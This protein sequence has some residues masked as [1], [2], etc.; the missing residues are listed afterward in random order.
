[1]HIQM[2]CLHG[3]NWRHIWRAMPC[4]T[5]T[6][7]WLIDDLVSEPDNAILLKHWLTNEINTTVSNQGTLLFKLNQITP[8]P[9][10][11]ELWL[12]NI[13][14]NHS[15]WFGGKII[16]NGSKAYVAQLLW[17]IVLLDLG[18]G[19]LNIMKNMNYYH[20]SLSSDKH[21]WVY[22]PY[23][24]LGHQY[25]LLDQF[26]SYANRLEHRHRNQADSLN[27]ALTFVWKDSPAHKC[28]PSASAS[29]VCV[30]RNSIHETYRK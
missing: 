17:Q 5:D 1:M 29:R 10:E 20:I 2:L 19:A 18:K 15:R 14:P 6:R 21:R 23:T 25:E 28:L 27:I 24:D 16:F 26:E 12:Q 3:T 13:I 22:C 11:T 30:Y 8:K 9:N 4:N 7:D